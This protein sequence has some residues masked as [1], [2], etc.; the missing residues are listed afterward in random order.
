MQPTLYH[1][2]SRV[3]FRSYSRRLVRMGLVRLTRRACGLLCEACCAKFFLAK[4]R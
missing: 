4:Q 3:V 1:A 2:A